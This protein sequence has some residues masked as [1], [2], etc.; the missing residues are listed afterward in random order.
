[1]AHIQKEV[2]DKERKDLF[3]AGC[4]EDDIELFATLVSKR[5]VVRA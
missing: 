5:L 4:N 3:N 1:M 2:R